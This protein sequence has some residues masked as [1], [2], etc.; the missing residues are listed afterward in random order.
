VPNNMNN[1]F[2]FTVFHFLS[3]PQFKSELSEEIQLNKLNLTVIANILIYIRKT[4]E[5][6][7]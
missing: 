7:W 2:P 1:I 4:V 5:I 3:H 6:V